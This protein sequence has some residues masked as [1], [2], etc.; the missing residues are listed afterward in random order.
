MDRLR[1]PGITEGLLRLTFIYDGSFA[2]AGGTENSGFFTRYSL[3]G[4][5]LTAGIH[6]AGHIHD[7]AT[8]GVLGEHAVFNATGNRVGTANLNNPVLVFDSAA[9]R[10]SA[11]LAG[12]FMIP[13]TAGYVDLTQEFASNWLCEAQEGNP[14]SLSG[15]FLHTAAV[16]G[17]LVLDLEG[18]PISGATITSESGFDYSRALASP[19]P[20]PAS[21]LLFA[22]GLIAVILRRRR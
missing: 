21:S 18:N 19:V 6:Y 14:C 4:N 3:V 13:F 8:S 10:Y 5:G 9:K 2:Y 12:T 11:T 17:A 7:N 20:E 1:F 15:D 22:T 16:G